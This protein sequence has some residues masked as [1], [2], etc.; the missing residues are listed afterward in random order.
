MALAKKVT[1]IMPT[2]NH[3]GLHL[4]LTDDAVTVID[5]DYMEPWAK[6]SITTLVKIAIG[7]RMQADI[8]KYKS[9]KAFYDHEDYNTAVTQV[10]A[11]LSL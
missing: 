6:G 11:G 7:E 2:D 1:K 8:D 3:V 4:L 9:L 5:K 10:D